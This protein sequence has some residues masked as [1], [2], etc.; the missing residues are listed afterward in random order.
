MRESSFVKKMAIG[1]M[2][3]ALAFIFNYLESLPPVPIPIPGIK[4]GLANLVTVVTL[5]LLGERASLS[6]SLV[7]ILLSSGLYSMIYSMAGGVFSFLGMRFFKR[8]KYGSVFGVSIVGGALHN[9][10]QII[11][12]ILVLQSSNIFT[13]LGILL[14]IGVFTGFVIGFLSSRILYLLGKKR[15]H[16]CLTDG[17]IAGIFVI[18]GGLIL[19]GIQLLKETGSKVIVQKDSHFYA[20]YSLSVDGAYPLYW[21]D[22]NYN[23]LTIQDGKASIT[24]ASCPD[25]LCVKER[26]I[27]QTQERII[28]LPNRVEIFIEGEDKG[29]MDALVE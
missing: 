9:V 2:L 19:G 10:G 16:F 14:P 29:E 11:V 1:G 28:C 27:D 23:I 15:E 21:G 3:T 20:E 18:T 22:G 24:E 6:I 26:P 25:L 4:L 12:A 7:R 8:R 5:Y 13:Y 17:I